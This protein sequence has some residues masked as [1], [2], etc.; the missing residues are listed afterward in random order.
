MYRDRLKGGPVLLSMT[1]ANPGRKFSQPRAHLLA[2][3]CTVYVGVAKSSKIDETLLIR[4]GFP[5]KWPRFRFCCPVISHCPRC[6]LLYEFDLLLHMQTSGG[7]GFFALS[8]ICVMFAFRHSALLLDGSF[9]NFN[10]Q[11]RISDSQFSIG[12][13]SK[14]SRFYVM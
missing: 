4:I 8:R 7:K 9:I 2:E 1:Q 6:E 3:P 10:R 14:Q 11:F 5:R 13:I 12:L